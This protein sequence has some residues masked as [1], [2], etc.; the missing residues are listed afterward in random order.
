MRCHHYCNC[1]LSCPECVRR[2]WEWAQNHTRHDPRGF[3]KAAMRFQT[4]DDAQRK[5]E[6]SNPTPVKV[7]SG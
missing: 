7:R 4:D 1:E 2:F 6:D 5:A 3:I